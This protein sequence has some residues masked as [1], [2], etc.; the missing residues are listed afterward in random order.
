MHPRTCTAAPKAGGE[1]CQSDTHHKLAP[2]E[3][4]H[5]VTVSPVWSH[6]ARR[7]GQ[8][9]E[10]GEGRWQIKE[11]RKKFWSPYIIGLSCPSV[12]QS[13]EQRATSHPAIVRL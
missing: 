5:W 1:I 12:W 4:H 10:A 7:L 2:I 11:K 8:S 3:Y 13:D 6:V 9:L